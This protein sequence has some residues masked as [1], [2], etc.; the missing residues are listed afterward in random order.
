MSRIIAI[1]FI[2]LAILQNLSCSN[3]SD[4]VS[5]DRSQ[6]I[7]EMKLY[8][9]TPGDQYFLTDAHPFV[10]PPGT[11][12]KDALDSLGRNLAQYYFSK[13]Y[14]NDVT[15]I[16]FEVIRI[17]ELFTPSRPLRTA[18]I[19]MIDTNEYAMECFF[20]GSTGAQTTFCMLASTFL[21]PH[22][23]PPLVD[24]LVILY[25]GKILRELDHI[26]LSGIL[27]PR[28]V[29]FVAQRAIEGAKTEPAIL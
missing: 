16:H 8:T 11:S 1:S 7:G 3:N 2:T 19:N 9:F 15:D 21:Q 10:L 13:T 5:T 29:R 24:G 12:V 25:N 6:V 26:N 17:D 23:E 14:T 28:L 18:V 22:L 4:R 20:Q 27:T